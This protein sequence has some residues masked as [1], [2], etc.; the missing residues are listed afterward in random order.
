MKKNKIKYWSGLPCSP[1]GDLPDPGMKSASLISPALADRFF[2][3]QT[4]GNLK[5]ILAPFYT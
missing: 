3:I 5:V 4:L 1:P 2:I